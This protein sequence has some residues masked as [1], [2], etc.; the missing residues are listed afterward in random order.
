VNNRAFVVAVLCGVLVAGCAA[1]RFVPGG[2]AWGMLK[3]GTTRAQRLADYADCE[4]EAIREVP[5]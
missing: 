4:L 5:Q 1:N 2:P 3:E